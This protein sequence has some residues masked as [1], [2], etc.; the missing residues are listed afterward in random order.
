[1]Y[2]VILEQLLW[3]LFMSR[4]HYI[5][6][7]LSSSIGVSVLVAGCGKSDTSS[8]I[9]QLTQQ[10]QPN[11]QENELSQILTGLQEI[12]QS[13]SELK[14]GGISTV[15]SD[16][17]QSISQ[18][19]T[20]NSKVSSKLPSSNSKVT[21]KTAKSK[22]AKK[23]KPDNKK[24][25]QEAMIKMLDI[26]TKSPF[27]DATVEKYEHQID[28]PSNVSTNKL[29]LLSKSNGQTKI[30]VLFSSRGSTGVKLKYTSG[31][32]DKIKVRPNGALSFLTTDLPKTDERVANIN[33]YTLDQTDFFG[34]AK[35]LSKGYQ[36]EL[37]GRKKINGE[38]INVIK[39]VS[40]S[41]TNAMDSKITHE[42]LGYEPNTYKIR[43]WEAYDGNSKKKP[44]YSLTLL[45]LDYP[46]NIEESKFKI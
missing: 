16:V 22:V 23:A 10:I 38:T 33:G 9:S 21:P 36:A 45:S 15:P 13:I 42:H 34:M 12:K 30:D 40:N 31:Q 4:N 32:G 43:M 1:M 20:S 29:H 24:I 37:I 44:F 6:V 41:G 11:I 14:G 35:R 46:S 2:C 27:I 25:G 8:A 26:V 19:P 17:S 3:R 5:R 39:V 28:D 7:L 18:S